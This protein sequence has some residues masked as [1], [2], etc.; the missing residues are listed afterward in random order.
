[1]EF[2]KRFIE[3]MAKLYEREIAE[4][5]RVRMYIDVRP[6]AS[7]KNSIQSM[8]SDVLN[9]YYEELDGNF[10]EKLDIIQF[11][12]MKHVRIYWHSP[13]NKII[14]K[15]YVFGDP[16]YQEIPKE[17]FLWPYEWDDFYKVTDN[18]GWEQ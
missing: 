6:L 11:E 10:Q 2:T 12:L 1:M 14:I 8:V 16:L 4:S 15:Y 18:H 9:M 3:E 17:A 7:F 13:T 5:E